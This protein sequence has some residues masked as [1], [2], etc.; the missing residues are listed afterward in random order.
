MKFNKTIL[1]FIFIWI[2]SVAFSQD[3]SKKADASLIKEKPQ[4]NKSDNTKVSSSELKTDG[5]TKSS[6]IVKPEPVIISRD[7]EKILVKPK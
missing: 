5:E 3:D 2:S 4:E 6:G 7:E 1:L